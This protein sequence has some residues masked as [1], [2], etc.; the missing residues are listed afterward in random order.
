MKLFEAASAS[1]LL[2]QTLLV[3]GGAFYAAYEC[4]NEGEKIRFFVVANMNPANDGKLI[5]FTATPQIKKRR[6]H[7]GKRA[8]IVLVP[9]APKKY[10]GVTQPCVLDCESPVKRAREIFLKDVDDRKYTP[11]G[12]VPEPIMT[13]IVAAVRASRQLSA[14]EKRLVIGAI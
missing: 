4:L 7:H 2:R 5:L 6:A 12:T 3:R 9:L 8:D 10:N 11:A 1:S 13:M 14:V